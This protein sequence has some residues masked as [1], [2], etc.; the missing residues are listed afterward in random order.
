L[1]RTLVLFVAFAAAAAPAADMPPPEYV[2]AVEFSYYL[3]PRALWERELAWLK[4][5]GIRTV[6]FSIPWNWHQVEPGQLD[7][8]G[9]TSPRRDLQGFIKLLRRLGLRAWIRPLP[10]VANWPHTGTPAGADAAAR[11]TWL[12]ALDDLLATQTAA[13]GGPILFVEGRGLSVGAAAPPSPVRTVSATD[14]AALLQSREAMAS[15]RGALLWTDVEDS[16]YPAG[17]EGA[18]GSLLRHGAVGLSGDERPAG[19]ALRRDAALLRSWSALLPLLQPL[20]MPKPAVGKLPDGVTAVEL[21]SPSASAVSVTN[22]SAQPFHDELHVFETALK[23]TVTIPSVTVPAGESLW[24]PVSVALGQNGLCR[25]CSNFSNAEHI[26]YATAE[27]LGIEYENGILAMEF[28]AP[29][30]GEVILQLEHQPV[31]PFLAGGKPSKFDWDD[32]AFRARLNIPANKTGDHRVRIG[33]AIE[34]PETSA[35]LNEA[36]R[37]VIGQKNTIATTYSSPSVAARSRLRLPEGYTAAARTRSPN[38][39]EYDISV[40]PDAVHGD[41]ANIALEADGVLLGRARLQLFRPVS[42]RMMDAM[43]LHIGQQ[44]EMTPDPPVVFVEPKGSTNLE[45]SLRNNWPGIQTFR[46]EAAGEGLDFFPPKTEISIAAMDERRYSLRIFA[47][48][49]VTGLR[50]WH[51]KVAGGTAMDL[52]MRV[53]LLPRGRT[54]VWTA[55]LDG[56]G[57]PEWVLESQRVRAVF[58]SRDGGRWMEF[59]WKDTNTNFLPEQGAFAT[60]G[61]VEIHPAGEGL[62]IA[63]KGWKRTIRLTDSTLT[64]EQTPSLAADGLAPMAEGNV[65]LSMRRQGATQAIYTLQ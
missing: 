13:H 11:T 37:L 31:G 45:V 51:L 30:G 8:S 4:N 64:V 22:N 35:F 21:T 16:L 63:G 5:I 53:L 25:E 58:S 9:R 26:I 48:P 55:D 59:T 54:V 23:R 60:E 40:P 14:P 15:G 7:F 32:K 29:E 62:E 20:A 43:Q 42:I 52:P 61:A 47:Q 27:L 57:S 49:G 3:Y 39:I 24:L 46:L 50:D 41:F 10:P 1:I 28:A 19:A 65:H 36:H 6:E 17:W 18:P 56:D 12:K 38:E 44:T 2:Q 34:E 33:I